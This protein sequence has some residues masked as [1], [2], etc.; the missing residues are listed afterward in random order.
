MMATALN[1]RPL[2]VPGL[3][4][5]RCQGPFGWI[6][7]GAKDHDDAFREALRSSASA[8]RNTLEV[9]NGQAYVPTR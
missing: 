2:G 6:M 5:Y 1:E 8:D 3:T 9:W 7:I 4:S